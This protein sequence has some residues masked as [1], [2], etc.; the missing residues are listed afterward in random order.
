MIGSFET[1]AQMFLSVTNYFKG[2]T[3]K[4]VFSRKVGKEFVGVTYD[5]LREMVECFA[6]GLREL[7]AERGQRIGI[8]SE[9]RIEWVVAD[10]AVTG[11]GAVDVPIFPTLTGSQS[12]YIF[13]NCEAQII[14]LSNRMQLNKM[15]KVKNELPNVKYFIVMN[16]DVE[17]EESFVLKFSEVVRQGAATMTPQARSKW[18]EEEAKLVQPEDLLT[19]IYTSGTTGNP[20]GVMLTHRNLVANIYGCADALPLSET[21][22]LLSYLPMCHAYERASGY[23]TAFACHCTVAFAQS[24]DTVSENLPEVRPTVMTSVPRL[25][26]K[27]RNRIVSQVEKDTPTKQKIF[28]WAIN[29]GREMYWAK[30]KGFVSP[31]LRAQ[32]AL[33]DT[34]VFAKIRAKTGGRLRCFISGGAALPKELAEFFFA[35]GI[36]VLEGYG[37]TESSPVLSVTRMSDMEIGTIGTPLNN[38]VIRFAEDGEILAKGPNVMKGYWND[39]EAT[40]AAV[41]ADGWLHTGDIGMQ[42]ERGNIVITDRKKNIFVSSGGKNIAPQPIENQ[43]SQSRWIDQ[44]LLIGEKRDYISALIVPNFEYMQE[45]AKSKGIAFVNNR[46]LMEDDTVLREIQRDIDSLLGQFSKFEKVRK[47]TLIEKPF[48]VDDGEM[49][50]TLKIKRKV[51]EEKYKHLVEKMY[52]G[53]D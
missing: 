13:N 24:I 43:L 12:S 53:L 42:N 35:V 30:R 25:F 49:T 22:T 18:F 7:G 14:I 44:L 4:K 26:E 39:P 16:D 29:T 2:N 34:L 31:I 19:L 28:W 36:N 17:A 47:F 3:Q 50:P 1:I 48:T 10:F 15:L 45:M 38:V 8:L 23:Y 9:N 32:Y 27:I 5:E 20:K 33:A 11:M 46:D 51:V 40:S 37:L 21:D 41:D 52:E 6:V